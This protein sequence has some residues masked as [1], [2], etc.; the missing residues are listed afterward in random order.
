VKVPKILQNVLYEEVRNMEVEVIMP[1]LGQEMTEG[2]IVEWCK[3]ESDRV[4]NLEP[5]FLV[6]T[7]KATMDVESEVAGTLKKIVVGEDKVA[8]VGQVVA[9]IETEKS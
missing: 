2:R 8:V 7:S 3:K 4:E 6:D 1:R 9:I 5:L